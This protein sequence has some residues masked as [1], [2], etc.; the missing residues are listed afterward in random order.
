[1]VSRPPRPLALVTGASSGIGLEL[2]RELAR[3]QHDL[4]LVARDEARLRE[5]A[6]ELETA[7]GSTVTVLP[8]DLARPEA[9]ARIAA[10]LEEKG[11]ALQ[12]LVNNAGHGAFGPFTEIPLETEL[13]M[14]QVN[15]AALTALT[16]LLAP[17]M[18]ARHSGRI[19]NVASTAAFAPG[20]L[21][22]VYYATK[23]YVLSFSEALANELADTGV[24]VTALCPGPTQSGF[25]GRAHVPT[26][27]MKERELMDAVTVAQAGIDAAYQG[28]PVIIPGVMNNL[29]AHSVRFA[30]RSLVAKMVRRLQERRGQ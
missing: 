23:A 8:A 12:M 24:T 18:V 7:H 22:A 14:I 13:S 3:R 20:P 27:R 5:V 26:H 29:L 1:M 17:G 16:R 19:L 10:E 2:A 30:P 25:H 21:M 4:V 9:P 28:R 6:S 15:V 11:L